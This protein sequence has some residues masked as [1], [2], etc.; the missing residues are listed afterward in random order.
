MTIDEIYELSSKFDYKKLDLFIRMI[1]HSNFNEREIEVL[2]WFMEKD[3]NPSILLAP[4]FKGLEDKYLNFISEL[5]KTDHD[6]DNIV[7]LFSYSPKIMD[8]VISYYNSGYD[9][10]P[11]IDIEY[12][13]W[14]V[15]FLMECLYNNVNVLKLS[16]RG[17]SYDR[18]YNLSV[19]M[20]LA[21]N[22]DELIERPN[23]TKR[24]IINYF[25]ED[26]PSDRLFSVEGTTLD[27]PNKLETC[28]VKAPN[29]RMANLVACLNSELNSFHIIN[30]ELKLDGYGVLYSSLE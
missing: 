3:L 27:K 22:V 24:E 17:F 29:P 26:K 2:Y 16:N 14:Y 13:D 9:L 11:L 6:L 7:N 28:I 15:D 19:C 20:S 8:K 25:I 21:L 23:L 5:I 12:S 1:A 18:I 4:R 30:K 10:V